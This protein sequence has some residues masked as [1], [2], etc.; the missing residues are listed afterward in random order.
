MCSYQGLPVCIGGFHVFGGSE[1]VPQ[2]LL[3]PNYGSVIL[4]QPRP[5]YYEDGVAPEFP[6]ASGK[7][8]T[9]TACLSASIRSLWASKRSCRQAVRESH[10]LSGAQKK[11]GRRQGGKLPTAE[12]LLRSASQALTSILRDF[13]VSDFG[14]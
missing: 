3:D 14:T 7:I 1:A 13:A 2:V 4:G 11:P 8:K 9:A 5:I 10:S 12:P 6:P